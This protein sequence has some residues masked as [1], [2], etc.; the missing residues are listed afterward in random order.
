MARPLGEDSTKSSRAQ[1][2]QD[3]EEDALS[4][5]NTS[6]NQQLSI[7]GRGAQKQLS[8]EALEKPSME[9]EGMVL[10]SVPGRV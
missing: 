7:D 4:P 2:E 5:L 6:L 9:A 8:L 3:L 1:V 10:V